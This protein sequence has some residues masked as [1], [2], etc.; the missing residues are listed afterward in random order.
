MCGPSDSSYVRDHVSQDGADH[1]CWLLTRMAARLCCCCSPG[2]GRST[3]IGRD[4]YYRVYCCTS[5]RGLVR[6]SSLL[7]YSGGSR[8]PAVYTTAE[9]PDTPVV[10]RFLRDEADTVGS[11]GAST[12]IIRRCSDVHQSF[13]SP[14]ILQATCLATGMATPRTLCYGRLIGPPQSK[15]IQISQP[16]SGPLSEINLVLPNQSL[17]TNTPSTRVRRHHILILNISAGV[18][19]RACPLMRYELFVFASLQNSS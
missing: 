13:S 17:P 16:R 8:R 1:A 9:R 15:I 12:F 3:L 19:C 5:A 7:A 14:A 11:S 2:I 10:T 4:H 6:L 18:L